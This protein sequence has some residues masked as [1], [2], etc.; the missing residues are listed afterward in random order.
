MTR[1]APIVR[2]PTSEFPIWPGGQPDVL[3]RRAQ[4]RVRVARP[5]VVEDGRVR[6]LDRVPGAGR[7]AAP[8]V[9]DDERYE[10]VRRAAVSQIAVK[11]STSSEAPPT[12]AP[13]TSSWERSSSAF[14]GFTEPP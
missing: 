11:E 10:R 5:E 8:A 12:S 13:S 9:E 2:W 14:S 7:R 1:P 3:A 6:Q 4:R